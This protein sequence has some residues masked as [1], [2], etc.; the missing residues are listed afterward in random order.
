M[1]AGAGTSV[2]SRLPANSSNDSGRSRKRSSESRWPFL[3]LLRFLGLSRAT[4]LCCWTR[5]CTRWVLWWRWQPWNTSRVFQAT[6]L[7]AYLR[8]VADS[9]RGQDREAESPVAWTFW[10]F[11]FVSLGLRTWR[12]RGHVRCQTLSHGANYMN[13]LSNIVH[14]LSTDSI[15]T[16]SS[17]R[18]ISFLFDSWFRLLPPLFH[19]GLWGFASSLSD[20]YDV[21]LLSNTILQVWLVQSFKYQF[22]RYFA[23][24]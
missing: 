11:L 20:Q 14:L 7:Q 24:W 19:F 6:E 18:R 1:C 21:L 23:H 10:G 2:S 22:C 15:L 8:V 9:R 4:S 17:Q 12:G 16:L 13:L 3:F 5:R